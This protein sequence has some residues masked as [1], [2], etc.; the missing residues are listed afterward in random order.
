MSMW[1]FSGALALQ[2]I[3]KANKLSERG[4]KYKDNNDDKPSPP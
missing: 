2:L 3:S 1:Q 4:S